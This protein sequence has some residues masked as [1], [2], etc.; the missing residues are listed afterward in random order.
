MEKNIARKLKTFF[1]N[2]YEAP[3]ES[4]EVF[5]RFLNPKSFKKNEI[6]KQPY[7]T[8]KNLYFIING[9][10]GIFLGK[11]NHDICI[12]L[13]FD[14]EFLND[15]SS[16]LIQQESPLYIMALEKTE[17][18][19]ISYDNLMELYKREPGRQLRL[20]IAEFLFLH[21]QAQ[22]IEIL[23]MTAEERYVQWLE[24][25]P[26]IVLRTPLKHL[27]SYLGITPESLSR[28]RKKLS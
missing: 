17:V 15:Y 2:Y 16:F 25:N 9:L 26:Q 5:A 7:S 12:D 13:C 22:Q 14:N 21:K 18:L 23:T 8:E 10:A 27:A 6:I 24:E 3:L 20:V 19:S 1:D 11:D 28:I 4:W